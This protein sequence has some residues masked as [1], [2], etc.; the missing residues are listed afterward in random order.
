MSGTGDLLANDTALAAEARGAS[1]DCA[2]N[3]C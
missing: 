3:R 1:L 2:S